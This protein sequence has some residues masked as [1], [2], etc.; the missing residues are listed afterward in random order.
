MVTKEVW[1]GLLI[2]FIGTL[3]GSACAFFMR[4][5]LKPAVQ[6]ALQGFA[7]GV[8]IA[9]SVLPVAWRFYC[10]LTARCRICTWITARK[11]M[12]PIFPAQ[13]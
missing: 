4:C 13:R 9:A 2:P 11:G 6:K 8:M 1:I 5:E 12:R 7:A 10:S 3:L